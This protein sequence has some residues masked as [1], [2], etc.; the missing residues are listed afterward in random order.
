MSK[1]HIRDYAT[2][3]FIFYFQ[4]G[5]LEKYK[6]KII[7]EIVKNDGPSAGI[8]KPTESALIRAEAELESKISIIQDLEAV[9]KTLLQLITQGRG[10]IV[11]AIE[12]VYSTPLTR[13]AI[14]NRVIK[15]AATINTEERTVY[16][17]LKKARKLFA[18]NR[19]LRV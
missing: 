11:Q 6:E 4:N 12:M 5:P 10:D 17:Y 2:T 13:G 8:S 9:E 15:T 1:D 18:V 14:I 3:A 16:R 19:G 7:A